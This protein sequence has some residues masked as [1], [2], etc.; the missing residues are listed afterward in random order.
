MPI[1]QF[2]GRTDI[3]MPYFQGT[4]P[5]ATD[6]YTPQG[7]SALTG[8]NVPF[9]RIIERLRFVQD[10]LSTLVAELNEFAFDPLTGIVSML[11]D[12]WMQIQDNLSDINAIKAV[13]GDLATYLSTINMNDLKEWV[14]ATDA[15]LTA[16]ETDIATNTS[17]LTQI[18]ADITS[19]TT[20]MNSVQQQIQQIFNIINSS[21]ASNVQ[22][23]GT[24]NSLADLP[25]LT[26]GVSNGITVVRHSTDFMTFE[27]W[28]LTAFQWQRMFDSFVSKGIVPYPLTGTE[29]PPD[30]ASQILFLDDSANS[31]YGYALSAQTFDP[32]TQ[33]TTWYW[34]ASQAFFTQDSDITTPLPAFNAPVG[35]IAAVMCEY[36][37][38]DT[39]SLPTSA[40]DGDRCIVTTTPEQHYYQTGG[41]WTQ[42]QKPF[43]PRIY[44]CDATGWQGWHDDAPVEVF[45]DVH[46]ETASLP[47]YPQIAICYLGN[48]FIIFMRR[49]TSGPAVLVISN[50]TSNDF[51]M[52]FDATVSEW[53]VVNGGSVTS[54]VIYR[55]L[56]A[57]SDTD[58]TSAIINN[59]T[60]LHA[61]LNLR[62]ISGGVPTLYAEIDAFRY[63]DSS[64][65]NNI[66]MSLHVRWKETP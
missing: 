61:V 23:L 38:P 34:S 65:D 22:F 35:A 7:S 8:M 56:T 46:S 57:N 30:A 50:M 19:L 52:F 31:Q 37:V 48:G 11:T 49:L 40:R 2:T 9:D 64:L 14:E 41:T 51:S 29:P 45:H 12:Y 54:D 27:C 21:V 62:P 13:L 42:V 10:G 1:T 6:S 43:S 63:M 53:S 15:R 60:R 47:N 25:P 66:V 20:F 39:S 59:T 5:F 24:F 18:T 33:T 58:I 16:D 32:Q 55:T 17:Q 26:G 4:D 36:Q 28:Q 44:A 3:A